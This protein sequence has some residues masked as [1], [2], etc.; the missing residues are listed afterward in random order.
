M[1]TKEHIQRNMQAV[2]ATGS[3]LEEKLGKSLWKSNFRYRKHYKNLPGKPDF[4]LVGFK[5]TIFCDSH[6]WHGYKWEERKHD[7]KINKDF[8]YKKIER[9]IERDKE[10][11]YM[12]TEMGWKV[13]RFWEHEIN[14]DV[15]KCVERVKKEISQ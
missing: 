9:N 12:L 6:F 13:I 7:H 15:E 5:I 14:E 11:N 4:V 10:V 2:R 1:R 3:K 8:W